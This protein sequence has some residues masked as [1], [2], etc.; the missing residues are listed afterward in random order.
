MGHGMGRVESR[1][2]L[3][4]AVGQALPDERTV[5]VAHR[6]GVGPMGQ[7]GASSSIARE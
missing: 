5:F 3:A 7:I 2:E 1:V 6:R 4:D